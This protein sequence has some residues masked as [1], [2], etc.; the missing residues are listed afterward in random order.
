M[1]PPDSPPRHETNPLADTAATPATAGH[2]RVGALLAVLGA[3]T[4]SAPLATDMYVPGLPAMGEALGASSS[5]IQLTMTTFL[6]G[7]VVGQLFFG[8]LSDSLGRRRLLIA[9]SAGFAVFS[10]FCAVSPNVETLLAARFLQGVSGAI[11]M[12]L[13]RAVITDRFHGRD[14][15]KYFAVLSQILGVA[16][17][18]APV[19]GGAVLAVSTWRIVFV[20]LAVIGVGLAVSV[21]VKV[22][23]SLPPE[24]RHSGGVGSSFRAMSRLVATR[25]FMGYVLVL[26]FTGAALFAYIGGSSFV[27][28]D[29]HGVSSTVYSLIFAA[30]A[31]G[32]LIAGAT[33]GRLAHR[34]SLHALLVSGLAITTVASLAQVLVVTLAGESLAGSWICLFVGNTGIGLI[35]PAS[36][37]LGQNAGRSAPGGASA[38]LGAFQ[39]TFGALATPLVGAFG[40]ESSQPMAVIMLVA[41]LGAVLAVAVLVRPWQRDSEADVPATQ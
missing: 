11:G 29:I 22:P 41:L 34:V 30:N 7:L 14:I 25:R 21:V 40:E 4:A 2:H 9:G 39:F 31:V 10:L 26:G 13:A 24:R 35:F 18:A 37:S 38:L 19:I 12:A 17:I 6:I 15:P 16:P 20:V 3:L 36:M 8:P 5:T 32:V 27:F 28:Q 1:L 23:E 33:F